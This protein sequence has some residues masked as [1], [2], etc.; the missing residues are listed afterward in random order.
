MTAY[1][2]HY[3][4]ILK[5]ILPIHLQRLLPNFVIITKATMN[6]PITKYNFY[7]LCAPGVSKFTGQKTPFRAF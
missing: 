7:F 2:S 4:A 1:L 3:H 5:F 6:I